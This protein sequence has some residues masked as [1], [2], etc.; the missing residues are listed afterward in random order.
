MPLAKTRTNCVLGCGN[1]NNQPYV[2]RRSSGETR[3]SR[4]PLARRKLLD[5]YFEAVGIERDDVY[6]ANILKCRLLRTATRSGGGGKLASLSPRSGEAD[7][8]EDNSLPRQD[9]RTAADETGL[10]ITKEHGIW[11]KKAGV[12]MTTVYH[13]SYLLR[14]NPQAR[15]QC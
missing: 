6:I 10:R 14:P 4:N 7:T 8:A 9:I 2:Y 5:K 13:P 12:M 1:R 15:E 11:V 3:I